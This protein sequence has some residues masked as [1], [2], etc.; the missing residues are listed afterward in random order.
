MYIFNVVNFIN[1][2]TMKLK[3]ITPFQY[4]SGWLQCKQGTNIYF[5]N[6][7]IV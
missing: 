3:I 4:Y 2:I 6:W 1:N 5:K 7:S